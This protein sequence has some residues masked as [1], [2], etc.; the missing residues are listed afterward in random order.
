MFWTTESGCYTCRT[1]SRH[2]DSYASS[3]STFCVCG[4]PLGRHK[5][6]HPHE[7][8]NQSCSK[9]VHDMGFPAVTDDQ[10]AAARKVLA[11]LCDG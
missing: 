7:T 8:T 5:F 3:M 11:E 4:E 9:Y 10:V 2:L 6:D 1:Y